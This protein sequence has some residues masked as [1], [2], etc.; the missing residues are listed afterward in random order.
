MGIDGGPLSQ[1]VAKFYL[2]RSKFVSE[3]WHFLE[4]ILRAG[5]F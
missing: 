4:T 3:S 2:F 5:F 1:K